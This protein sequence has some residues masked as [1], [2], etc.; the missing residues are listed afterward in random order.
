[1]PGLLGAPAG[2]QQALE[3]HGANAR[4]HAEHNPV[5]ALVFDCDCGGHPPTMGESA[6]AGS[7]LDLFGRQTHDFG[8]LVGFEAGSADQRAVDVR[9]GDER[10]EVLGGDTAAVLDL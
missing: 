10:G 2:F 1:V 3:A 7:D 4:G 5:R 6:R 9:L 8:E